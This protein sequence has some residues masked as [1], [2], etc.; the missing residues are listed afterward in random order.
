MK[1]EEVVKL[2]DREALKR[3]SHVEDVQKMREREMKGGFERLETKLDRE[4]V[5][6]RKRERERESFFFSFHYIS[7]S[8]ERGGAA[9]IPLFAF[10]NL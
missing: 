7:R 3:Q 8:R 4:R 10:H 5:W 6:K 2:P 9:L 1:E